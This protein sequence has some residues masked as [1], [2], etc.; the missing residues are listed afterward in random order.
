MSLAAQR[1][2]GDLTVVVAVNDD[3]PD[4]L[5]V[6]ELL[7]PVLRGVGVECTVVHTAPGRAAALSAA[8][9]FLPRAP[10][11]YLD[12]DAALSTHA[13]ADLAAV[14]QPGT[15]VHFAAPAVRF[16]A[17]RSA[18]SRA[19]FQAWSRLPYV[20]LSPVACGA[21]AV[22]AAG[23][24]RWGDLPAIH[25]DDKWVRWHFAPHE[26]RVVGT[27]TYEVLPPDG[28]EDLVRARLR[29]RRGNRE[30]RALAQVPAHADDDRRYQHLV[31][32]MVMR[33]AAWS[34]AL[35]MVAVHAAVAV[36]DHQ[37]RRGPA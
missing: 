16:A 29:Y 35:V 5:A 15:G 37:P 24:G 30:L 7:A 36:L 4:S 1:F 25:S 23:R 12:Q 13:V 20:Q 31:R 32:R 6:A 8:D 34:P 21:Y 19:Y 17:C 11:L 33:P 27:S 26:R 22:S 2:D 3:R 18:V 14:L 9:R 28:I 10:R